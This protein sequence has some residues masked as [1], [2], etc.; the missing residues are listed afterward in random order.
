MDEK[1]IV[2]TVKKML[3]SGV[4]DLTITSTLKDIG[5]EENEIQGFIAKAKGQE[6]P[7]TTAS[8]PAE[9]SLKPES[10]VKQQLS[11]LQSKQS[12][13][14][15][16]E[17]APLPKTQPASSSEVDEENGLMETQEKI[18]GEEHLE[19][20][21]MHGKKIDD[22][23]ANVGMLHE[24][25]ESSPSFQANGKLL[26]KINSLQTDLTEVKSMSSALQIILKQILETNR[27]TLMELQLKKVKK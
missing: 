19:K 9:P 3:S 12:P 6:A 13:E 25:V 21:D 17:P 8:K 14:T 11:E 5:I 24:K 26:E 23:N 15:A 18:L 1:V 16:P 20:L 4:D 22:L 10:N 2:D 27:K 7:V